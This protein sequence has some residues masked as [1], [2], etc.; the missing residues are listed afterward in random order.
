MALWSEEEIYSLV[1]FV[2]S[3]DTEEAAISKFREEY[4]E[5]SVTACQQKLVRLGY[6]IPKQYRYWSDREKDALRE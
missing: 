1:S 6:R 5:R 4:T 2:E 3:E